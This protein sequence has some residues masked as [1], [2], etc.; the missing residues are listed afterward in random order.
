MLQLPAKGETEKTMAL[1]Q[2]KRKLTADEYLAIERAA[3]QRSEFFDGEMFA[4]SGGTFPHSVIKLNVGGEL[5]TALEGRSCIAFDNDTRLL[6]RETGLF[7]YADAGVVCGP[8]EFHDGRTDTLLNPILVAE[9][10]SP[11][12]EAYDRGKKFKHYQRISTL[13]QYLLVAQDEPCL[14]LFTR[15]E[16]GLWTIET[17]AGIDRSI[18]LGSVGVTLALARVYLNVDFETDATD[19]TATN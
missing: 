2:R 5:R 13:R 18:T 7:T 14:E 6:V 10:L 12:T 1:P 9:V 15:Q 11:S 16:D 17:V 4:M 3:E 19:S 8:R